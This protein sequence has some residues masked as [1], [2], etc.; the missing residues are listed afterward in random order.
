M[1][2]FFMDLLIYVDDIVI[3]SNDLTQVVAAESHSHDL[4]KIK[5]LEELKYYLD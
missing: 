2:I 3:V 5:D 4:F 1:N